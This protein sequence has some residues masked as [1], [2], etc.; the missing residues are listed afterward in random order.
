MEIQNED[1]QEVIIYV[2]IHDEEYLHNKPRSETSCVVEM[3]VKWQWI[4]ETYL[5]GL[6]SFNPT[7]LGACVHWNKR[8]ISL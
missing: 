8:H 7:G 5:V 4:C 2:D 3:C 6:A 1:I